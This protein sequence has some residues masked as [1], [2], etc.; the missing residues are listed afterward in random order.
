MS[1]LVLSKKR[2]ACP[3]SGSLT[4]PTEGDMVLDRSSLVGEGLW[5]VPGSIFCFLAYESS[6][7]ALDLAFERLSTLTIDGD[8]VI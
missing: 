2:S 3:V 7:S 8:T 4:L 1:T 6:M 5:V